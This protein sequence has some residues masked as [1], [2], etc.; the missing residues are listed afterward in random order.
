MQERHV[1]TVLDSYFKENGLVKQQIDSYNRFTTDL[2]D[3]IN[4][5]GK[6]TIPVHHQFNIGEAYSQEEKWEFELNSKLYKTHTVHKNSDTT[7]IRV[8]PMMC[9]LRDLNYES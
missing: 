4:E 1:W 2:Q 7:S 6:F 3:V 5:Y 9:R 8:N